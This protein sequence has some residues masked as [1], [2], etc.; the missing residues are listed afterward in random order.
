[1]AASSSKLTAEKGMDVV[2]STLIFSWKLKD[3]EK[4]LHY[5]LQ[6]CI[7]CGLCEKVCPVDAI[8]MGP[9][10]EVANGKLQ[11][12]PLV[13]ID[14]EKCCYCFL[15]AAICPTA[16][17]AIEVNPRNKIDLKEF[18]GV[19]LWF[20]IDNDKCK[21]GKD[22]NIC[23]ACG[24]AIKENSVK[25]IQPIIE[26]CPTGA[27]KFRTPF[28]GEVHLY[29]PQLYRCDLSNCKVCF[30][31]CPSKAIFVPQK[32]DDALKLGKIAVDQEKCILCGACEVCPEHL[33]K[34]E[35]RKVRIDQRGKLFSWSKAWG[36]IINDLIESRRK[37]LRAQQRPISMPQGIVAAPVVSP[38]KKPAPLSEAQ[39][40]D[41]L[42]IA[43][44]ATSLLTQVKV[45]RWMEQG[46]ST[47]LKEE[48]QKITQNKQG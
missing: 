48:I 41:N 3:F 11:E 17:I 12:T 23:K 26:K 33:F 18:P 10:V 38:G 16:A 9:V 31:L 15:C 20:E 21:N 5:D 40:K 4:K 35:R 22:P 8:T 14:H 45:R 25:T 2:E 27:L 29:T 30:T 24:D 19:G 32:A 46:N 47:K 43:A 6:K 37:Q 36:D 1:M 44:R 7:G 42:A 28:E 39:L 34:V 13:V